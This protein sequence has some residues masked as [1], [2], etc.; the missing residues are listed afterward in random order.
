MLGGSLEIALSRSYTA[1]AGTQ[2]EAGVLALP[3]TGGFQQV[4]DAALGGALQAAVTLEPT[5]LTVAVTSSP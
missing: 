3:P 1:T 4:N 2:F 5:A